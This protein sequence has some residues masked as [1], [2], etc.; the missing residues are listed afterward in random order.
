MDYPQEARAGA[1]ADCVTEDDEI[2]GGLNDATRLTPDE[3]ARRPAVDVTRRSWLSASNNA[4]RRRFRS[5]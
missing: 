1:E 5:G 3:T 2:A 4:V